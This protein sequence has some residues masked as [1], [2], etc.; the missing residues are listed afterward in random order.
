MTQILLDKDANDNGLANMIKDLLSQNIL[1]H[2]EREKDLKA[3]DGNIVIDANDIDVSLTLFCKNG[4]VL[5]KNGVVRPYNIK[6]TTASDNIMKLSLLRI[7]FK[8]PYYFDKAGREVIRLIL[9]GKLKI[10]GL[11]THPIMLTHLTKLFSVM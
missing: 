11:V 6:I 8:L 5:I 9:N 2:P 4:D 1:K 7:K 3:L 10:D